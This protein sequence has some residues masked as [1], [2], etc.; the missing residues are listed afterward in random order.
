[1]KMLIVLGVMA[2]AFTS[3]AIFTPQEQ[4]EERRR[5]LAMR[6]AVRERHNPERVKG[7]VKDLLVGKWQ[8]VGLEVEEGNVY[9]QRAKPVPQQVLD[10]LN[11]AVKGLAKGVA[12]EQTAASNAPEQVTPPNSNVAT[13]GKDKQQSEVNQQNPQGDATRLPPIEVRDEKS[14]QRILG[15]KAALIASTRKNLILEFTED[16]SSYYY[17][18][19]NRGKNIAG[20]CYITTKRYG[21]DPHTFIRFNRRVG[22]EAIE[23]LFGSEP[24]KQIAAREKQ[25]RARMIQNRKMGIQGARKA[26]A[27]QASYAIASM[28][29]ITVTD[30]TLSLVLYGDME[31]TPTGWMRTGGLRCTFKRIE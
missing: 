19:S 4:Q 25:K 5:L 16:R 6:D 8:Y 10:S 30:D 11:T 27:R 14:N 21:D 17:S 1:M 31:L 18:G 9:A 24:V 23:F 13:P 7:A 3:C 20:Q 28:A 29:G 15:A 22:P 26:A 12:G 2:I